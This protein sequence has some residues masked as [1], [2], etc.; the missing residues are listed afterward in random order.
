MERQ[1]QS[2]VSAVGRKHFLCLMGT[3][4]EM[5]VSYWK[6]IHNTTTSSLVEYIK[7]LLASIRRL[8]N[9]KSLDMSMNITYSGCRPSN[10]MSSF[11]HS[12]QVFLPLHKH[13]QDHVFNSLIRDDRCLVVYSDHATKDRAEQ[14]RA[15]TNHQQV[16]W[17][18]LCL[19][20]RDC[21]H[22][23]LEIYFGKKLCICDRII[24]MSCARSNKNIKCCDG[25]FAVSIW[26]RY[27]W[28]ESKSYSEFFR[29]NRKL[30]R[31]KISSVNTSLSTIWRKR[32]SSWWL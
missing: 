19:L 10:F 15:Y 18:K 30:R 7:L 21:S 6:F 28:N 26:R 16:C 3:E 1:N 29:T 20:S 9:M 5:S 11:T 2:D 4:W 17:L 13:V 25:L 24:E 12:S 14:R 22:M 31:S 8:S 27:L 23:L 32:I